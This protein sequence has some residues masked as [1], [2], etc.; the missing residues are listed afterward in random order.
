VIHYETSMDPEGYIHR[1][2]RTGRAGA[3]GVTISLVDSAEEFHL[4]QIAK[5]FGIDMQERKAPTDADVE[6]VVS[7]RLTAL[8]EAHL[9]DRETLHTER[10]RRFL[11]LAR[12]LA[13][14]EDESAIIAM[15]L[16]E[17]YQQSLHGPIP[18]PARERESHSQTAKRYHRSD[19][20]R[21]QRRNRRR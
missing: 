15:L 8:L 16:D 19:R 3:P 4:V 7:E 12:D 18:K 2:G 21:P 1:S 9:R 17:Y 13:D 5:Q 11:A 10:S 20:G 6:A 14:N